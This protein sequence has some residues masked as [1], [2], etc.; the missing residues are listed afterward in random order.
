MPAKHSRHIALTEALASW[1]DAQVAKGEYASTSDLI[2]TAI[3][4]LR[5]RDEEKVAIR[6][7]STARPPHG[8][9]GA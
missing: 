2:R 7:A 8:A 9:G 3:R 5:S 6:S 4:V 1:V